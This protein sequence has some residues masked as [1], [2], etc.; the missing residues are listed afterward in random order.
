MNDKLKAIA[1][2]VIAFVK[3]GRITVHTQ[4]VA[5]G[6]GKSKT[7]LGECKVLFA[8]ETDIEALA[9]I[10]ER[11]GGNKYI[12]RSTNTNYAGSVSTSIRNYV[13][14]KVNPCS[15]KEAL[16]KLGYDAKSGLYLKQSYGSFQET[17]SI[18]KECKQRIAVIDSE[19]LPKAQEAGDKGLMMTLFA[20]QGELMVK[21][22]MREA[23]IA[24]G[25]ME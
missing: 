9:L 22:K 12:I 23:E 11:V 15:F 20:E 24:T 19:E 6:V 16:V 2:R 25:G 10:H 8:S 18:I 4:S 14:H 1:E 21:I 7:P 13:E 17:D 3:A 5:K